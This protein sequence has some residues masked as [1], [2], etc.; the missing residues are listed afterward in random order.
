MSQSTPASS[1]PVRALNGFK[2]M[3]PADAAKWQHIEG[4][5]RSVAGAFGYHE[6]R[7]PVLESSDVT[8]RGV[9][10][11]SDIVQKETY[12]F[13][14]RNGDSVTLRPEGTAG[15]VRAVIEAGLLNDMGARVKA[16]YIA[17]N[18]RHERPQKGR[19]RQHH[20]FGIECFGVP[21]PE[22]DVECILLQMA[23]YQRCGVRD[24]AL[25]INSMGD[26]ESK[27]RYRQALVA[28][29]T[30]KAAELSEDSQRRL[31]TNPLR[32]LDSKDPRDVKARE[33]V[34]A[35]AD[36]LTEK[37]KAHFDR[38]IELLNKAGV[39]FKIAPALVR[40]FDYYTDT[41]WEVTA[42]GL[43]SQSAIGGGGRYDLLVE[44]LGG[45][46][47]PG[48]GFG[49]GLERLLLAL[50][51]QGVELPIQRRPLVWLAHHGDAGRD[52]NLT[53][54]NHL[55]QADIATDLDLTG[56]GMKGQLKLADREKARWCVVVGDDELAKGVVQLK[57]LD[58]H[59]QQ[60]IEQNALLPTLVDLIGRAG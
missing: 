50:E 49:S 54:A 51:G 15:V 26:R 46:P 31:T 34:P 30:P 10:D 24:L 42:G 52:F 3:L 11:T 33:G 27:Q 36:S 38:V 6:I 16:W 41:L 56:R 35:P 4:I 44:H 48:V 58:A 5:A 9:G 25:V 55:R 22:Q 12:T 21:N 47:T 23:F 2:D 60:T 32:I 57:D 53:L 28:F 59:T 40:G 29:L 13:A 18:F 7:T 39:T 17:S 45:K 20:Q 43:G 37:S 19:L 14:D 1:N 8:H